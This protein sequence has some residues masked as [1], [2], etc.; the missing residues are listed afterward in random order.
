M[1][2]KT[3]TEQQTVTTFEIDWAALA[4][5]VEELVMDHMQAQLLSYADDLSMRQMF[6]QDTSDSLAVC[7]H[8]LA[9]DWT[10]GR[11]RLW[12]MDTAARDVVFDFI[13][14]V[15]GREFFDIVK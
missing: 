11:K 8:L 10:K 12:D 1:V 3:Q 14:I 5:G 2:I 6:V 7:E 13:E 9:G 15:A 4:A